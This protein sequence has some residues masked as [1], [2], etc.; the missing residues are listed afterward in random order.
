M[1]DTIAEFGTA[2]GDVVS[3][4]Y[5]FANRRAERHLKQY[6]AERVGMINAT[7]RKAVHKALRED[8]PVAAVKAVFQQAREH[9]AKMIAATEVVRTSNWAVV[10]AG[11]WVGALD[12]KRWAS[13]QDN[14]V[15]ETHIVLDGQVVAWNEDFTSP[16]GARAPGP[17][18]FGDPAEDIGCRCA[19]IPARAAQQRTLG[20]DPV[21]VYDEL[22]APLEEQMTEAWRAV[23]AEQE[24]AVLAELE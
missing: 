19:A 22:R 24:A 7:T 21:A 3:K 9:R 20:G 5:N 17:G 8:D 16:S 14:H 6:A 18:Q 1:I 10:D 15:R 23:F 13:Q 11:K 12:F 4:E 2:V